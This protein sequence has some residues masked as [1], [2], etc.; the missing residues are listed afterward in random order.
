MKSLVCSTML[1]C[2]GSI[3]VHRS[4]QHWFSTVH[5]NWYTWSPCLELFLCQDSWGVKIEL[6]RYH[7]T[8]I[9]HYS[10]LIV[11]PRDL[12]SMIERDNHNKAKFKLKRI[13]GIEDIDKEF[14]DLVVANEISRKIEHPW[15]N[16]LQKKYT[17][18]LTMAIMIPLF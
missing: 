14:N 7:G 12:N 18:H 17:P 5:H 13:K 4:T 8:C 3:K 16:L 1:I 2:N 15:R 9:N 10:R 6:R 11:P